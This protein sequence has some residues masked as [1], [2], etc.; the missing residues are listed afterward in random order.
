MQAFFETL[1]YLLRRCPR[2]SDVFLAIEERR[3][4]GLEGRA[5]APNF[6]HF[7]GLLGELSSSTAWE[8]EEMSVE[9]EQHFDSYE[10]VPQMHL[11]RLH[12]RGA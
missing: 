2:L 6:H 4:A 7:V 11:W 5:E 8:A 3:R 10:R 9:F 12:R 1:R